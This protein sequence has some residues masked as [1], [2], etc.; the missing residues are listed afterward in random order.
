MKVLLGQKKI[1]E[2]VVLSL[3]EIRLQNDAQFEDGKLLGV[4]SDGNLFKSVMTFRINSLKNQLHLS[5]KQ[6][7]R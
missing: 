6:Y 1:G 4:N 2:Y 3:D 5:L 7:L